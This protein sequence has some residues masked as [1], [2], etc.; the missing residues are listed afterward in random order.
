VIILKE[1]VELM[2]RGIIDFPDNMVI[3]QIIN[4][5]T[6]IFEVKVDPADVGK[7]IGKQG[8]NIKAIRSI[9][10]AAAQKENK[11]VIIEIIK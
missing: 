1:L 9:M 8:K 10:N 2:I 11:R 5:K 4:E 6:T 7:V 3:N